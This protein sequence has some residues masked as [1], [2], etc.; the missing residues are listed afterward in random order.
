[1][2]ETGPKENQRQMPNPQK[3]L[4]ICGALLLCT[5]AFVFVRV[6]TAQAP[7]IAVVSPTPTLA[8]TPTATP[9]VGV[10]EAKVLDALAGTGLTLGEY[11]QQSGRLPITL[12][13]GE[14]EESACE[15]MLELALREGFAR[16]FTLELQAI[17]APT[18][19]KQPGAYEQGQYD[20]RLLRYERDLEA[21]RQLV[22]LVLTAMLGAL[23][24]KGE[25]APG[26]ALLWENE[27]ES[28]LEDGQSY[29][30]QA[31]PFTFLAVRTRTGKLQ[32][33]LS[34]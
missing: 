5:L 29:S 6:Q 11:A 30:E 7:V 27:V 13:A 14:R 18:K 4:L 22:H 23:D 33:S 3:L 17:S 19:P 32:I 1:M 9:Q 10:R 16:G 31:G 8:P 2:N 34:R 20:G 24:S 15:G 12:P 21:Q 28:L 26:L 25:V